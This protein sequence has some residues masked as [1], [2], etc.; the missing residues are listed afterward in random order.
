MELLVG[1]KSEDTFN[2]QFWLALDGVCNA[3]DNIEARFYVD[4]QCVKYEKSLLE[5][6]TMGT[7]ANVGKSHTNVLIFPNCLVSFKYTY[8]YY[9]PF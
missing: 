2:D 1:P 6:G 7:G 9:C 8:R 4:T 3:L 5:S